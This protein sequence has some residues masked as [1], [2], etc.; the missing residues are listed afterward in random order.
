MYVYI[1]TCT[2]LYSHVFIDIYIY[3]GSEGAGAVGTVEMLLCVLQCVSVLECVAVCCSVL[4][5]VGTVEMLLCVL[6]CVAV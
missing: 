6:Q 3:R 1:H 2:H 5:Y 4:Q